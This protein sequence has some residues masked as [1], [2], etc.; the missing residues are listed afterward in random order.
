MEVGE[1][2]KQKELRKKYHIP[3]PE[4]PAILNKPGIAAVDSANV[5]TFLFR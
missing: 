5:S 1:S 4:V 2:K 3:I